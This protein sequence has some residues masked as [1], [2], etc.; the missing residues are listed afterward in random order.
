MTMKAEYP[1]ATAYGR[2]AYPIRV[3][4]RLAHLDAMTA[5]RWVEGYA[6]VTRGGERR[7]SAPIT[8]LATV[9]QNGG[10]GD[11]VLNFEQL[12]TLLLVKAFK[13]RGLGLPTIKRAAARAQ[14]VY[15]TPN[16]FVTKRFRSDGSQ[17]FIDLEAKDSQERRLI[18]I[19]SDQHEFREIVEPS[20]FKDVVFVD[21]AAEEW[22]PLGKGRA[23]VLAPGRQFG[24]PHI[25][26]KGVRTD[27]VAQAAVAEGG[28]E[29]GIQAAADWYGLQPN[30]VWDAVEFEG[31]WLT[32]AAA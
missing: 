24:A 27:I 23:V 3:A 4:A 10:D 31:E 14:Q 15:G 6:Y 7:H 16:P 17:V 25:A 30:Q 29:A 26:G 13:D 18:N 1:R 22:W 20:L 9:A 2:G 11:P 19:L 8:Y 32:N 28:G 5:R 21:D 12:L